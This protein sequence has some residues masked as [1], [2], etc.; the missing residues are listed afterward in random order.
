[1][2]YARLERRIQ[3]WA[4]Q[5][6]RVQAIAVY[7]SRARSE[8]PGDEWSDLDLILF[9]QDPMDFAAQT[10]WLSAF[11]EVWLRVLNTTGHGDPEWL[12]LFE[13]GLKADFLLTPA[14]DS[15]IEALTRP[16]FAA[17]T[18]RGARILWARDAA[19][20][21]APPP[22][23]MSWQPPTPAAFA[24]A[25]DAVALDFYRAAVLLQRGELWRA[26]WLTDVVLRQHLQQMILWQARAKYGAEYDTWHDGRFLEQWADP[27]VVTAL[28]ELFARYDPGES[29]RALL[30]SVDLY[31]RL[32][33]ETAQK[34]KYPNP[35]S[36]LDKVQ[37]WVGVLWASSKRL[38]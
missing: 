31:A 28:P 8:R 37:E 2:T 20:G 30:A 18:H 23:Q 17:A 22:T 4:A 11:G 29:K 7:G 34:W 26:R 19:Q 35:L 38:D 12:V 5:E 9:V 16:P 27:Q 24:A 6:P 10:D 15:V 36:G 3:E 1:M 32:S 21:A 14:R 13:G 25:V 33:A